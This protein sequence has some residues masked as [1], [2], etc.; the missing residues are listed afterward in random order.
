MQ[1]CYV[2]S[3]TDNMQNKQTLYQENS[4]K[5]S[6]AEISIL[7]METINMHVIKW[8]KKT[9]I[10]TWIPFLWRIW[11]DK[12]FTN[13]TIRTRPFKKKKS[14]S[15]PSNSKEKPPWI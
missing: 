13:F 14:K 9:V 1:N 8:D 5:E 12:I 11:N 6:E 7:L 10:S 3:T 2:E 15:P 4:K